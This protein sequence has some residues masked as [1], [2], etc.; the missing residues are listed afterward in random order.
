MSDDLSMQVIDFL[1]AF[2]LAFKL[3]IGH[4]LI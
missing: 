2:Y 4:I 3:N 1:F